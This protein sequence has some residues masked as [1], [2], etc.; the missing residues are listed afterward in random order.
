[1]A[2]LSQARISDPEEDLKL[3]T[4]A[5]Q[6][7]SRSHL[8]YALGYQYGENR[9]IYKVLGYDR[10]P[11]FENYRQ[12]YERLDIATRV[13]EAPA[14]ATWEVDPDVQ[15]DNS[16]ERSDFEAALLDLNDRVSLFHNLEQVDM[17]SGI[18][19][20]GVLV[21]G[22]A[23]GEDLSAPVGSS[24]DLLYLTPYSEGQ[25]RVQ[26][27]VRDSSDPRHGLPEYYSID[28][29]DSI[30]AD[31]TVSTRSVRV[32]WSRVLHVAENRIDNR[33]YG[34]PRLRSIYNRLGDIEKISGGSA[35]MFW[36][37]AFPGTAFV[38]DKDATFTPQTLQDLEDEIEEYVH[39]LKRYL[40]LQGIEP[41]NLAMQVADPSSH[42]DVQIQLISAATGIP[43]RI[44]VGSERGELA[45]SQDEASWG[46]R[47]RRRQTKYAGPFILRP[48][49][50]RM[51]EFGVLPRPYEGRYTITWPDP[52][53][54]G[55]KEVAGVNKVRTET[56]VAYSDSPG[57]S[58]VIP[59]GVFLQR[60]LDMDKEEVEEILDAAEEEQAREDL[61]M[62]QGE[63]QE[64]QEREVSGEIVEE[65]EQGT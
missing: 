26:T 58:A 11:K 30:S 54:P 61:E 51:I 5:S 48:C 1:M 10:D 56:L 46:R 50:D 55:D 64:A 27:L 62:E 45:S 6:I 28:V 15:D 42:L 49:I 63:S 29:M 44:L 53:G 65:E 35:E 59:P 34:T 7:V 25:A 8:A 40:R 47:V 4:L 37:G 60:F 19:R 43:K 20:Y 2:D 12:R 38:A 41:K 57:A 3:R 39:G 22:L 9:D 32:H 33:V 23:D 13:V 18:G 24:P 14:Q 16:D 31:T 52:V 17:I 36:R 21:F